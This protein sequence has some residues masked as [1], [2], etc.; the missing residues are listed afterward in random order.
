V[1]VFGLLS[2]TQKFLPLLRE[3]TSSAFRSKL[4][5]I[6][7][8]LGRLTIPNL[9]LYSSTKAAIESLADGMR[10]ELKNF[11]IDVVVIE[12]G[13]IATNFK[14]VA[15]ENKFSFF[16]SSFLFILFFC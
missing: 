15:L 11:D 16:F 3:G 10:V 4:L 14:T 13:V 9:S 12:P 2:V 5:F 1:N 6:S 8:G 7:S